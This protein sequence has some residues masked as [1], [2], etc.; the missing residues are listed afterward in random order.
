MTQTFT[1]TT[2]N[3]WEALAKDIAKILVPGQIFA[4]QGDLGAGKTTF[5]QALAA[6]MGSKSAPKSPTF[7]L[8]RTY[9]VK[10]TSGIKRLIHVDAYRIESDEDFRVL[11][12]DEEL[13]G[14]DAILALEWPE[15]VEGWIK[16][17]EKQVL[18]FSI[19]QEGETRHVTLE[20]I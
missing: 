12:L 17:H 14:G 18:M 4:L 1:I 5:V 7:S 10:T 11:D 20:Q 19:V 16:K 3:D 6:A 9:S 15:R 13:A 8:M 2:L